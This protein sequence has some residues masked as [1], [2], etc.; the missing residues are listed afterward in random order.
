M[1]EAFL[2][3]IIFFG[4]IALTAFIFCL[5]IVLRIG[6]WIGRALGGGGGV[7]GQITALPG[8]TV[9][10]PRPNC[11][12]GNDASATYCRRCGQPMPQAQRVGVR[13]V[14]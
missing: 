4:V 8:Q 1:G 3:I 2:T 6:G 11:R 9:T 13:R 10:C 14:A 7:G 12:A 5:W